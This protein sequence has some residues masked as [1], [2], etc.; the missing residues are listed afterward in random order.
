MTSVVL[1]LL[2]SMTEKVISY[3]NPIFLIKFY[4][5]S[6]RSQVKMTWGN[7]VEDCFLI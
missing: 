3:K 6:Q 4:E 5:P 1:A 7:G 2:V